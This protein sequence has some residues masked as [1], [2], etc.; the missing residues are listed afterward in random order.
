ML[1]LSCRGH[2]PQSHCVVRLLPKAGIFGVR[3]RPFLWSAFA[4]GKKVGSSA[5]LPA[6]FLL[7]LLRILVE[8]LNVGVNASLSVLKKTIEGKVIELVSFTGLYGG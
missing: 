7:S 1:L 8:K 5:D 6:K 4:R 3:Q 2:A